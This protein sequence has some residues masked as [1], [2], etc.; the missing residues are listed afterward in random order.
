MMTITRVCFFVT[1]VRND[2]LQSVQ[3]LSIVFRIFS[4]MRLKASGA[5]Q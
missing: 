5:F 3:V 4:T 1:S 2:F